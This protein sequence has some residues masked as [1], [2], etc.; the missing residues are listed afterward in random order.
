MVLQLDPS[1]LLA[2]YRYDNTGKW[3]YNQKITLSGGPASPNFTSIAFNE[4]RGFYGVVDGAIQEFSMT[5][6]DP[7]TFISIG[8]VLTPKATADGS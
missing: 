6:E 3:N 1:G 5:F 8:A 7:D 2:A 4:D